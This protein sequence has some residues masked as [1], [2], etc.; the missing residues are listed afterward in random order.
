MLSQSLSRPRL[1]SVTV[2]AAAAA[3][4][5]MA[6][7]LSRTAIW[8]VLDVTTRMTNRTVFAPRVRERGARFLV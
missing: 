4:A 8:R 3:A 6:F 5:S 2:A 1:A 7:M